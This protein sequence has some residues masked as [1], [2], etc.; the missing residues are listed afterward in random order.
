VRASGSSTE[1]G[2]EGGRDGGAVKAGE[3]VFPVRRVDGVSRGELEG[4]GGAGGGMAGQKEDGG[5]QA[6]QPLQFQP[7]QR[8]PT[9]ERNRSQAVPADGQE[10]LSAWLGEQRG[11]FEG[12][13]VATPTPRPRPRPAT[14]PFTEGSLLLGSLLGGATGKAQGAKVREV[15]GADALFEIATPQYTPSGE[16]VGRW[17]HGA[18]GGQ[19]VGD[20]APRWER[21]G[22]AVAGEWGVGG[23]GQDGWLPASYIDLFLEEY[24]GS[25]CVGAEK[26]RNREC[27]N[28]G[29]SF[30][31]LGLG[32][33]I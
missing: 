27:S 20:R 23:Q 25:R 21:M 12:P 29:F 30:R 9:L 6:L 3:V 18:G 26:K 5:A 24:D 14:N 13:S 7:P 19:V 33:R 10:S 15:F 1:A 32:F 8:L 28:Q 2:G 4:R 11:R 31:V 16:A 17:I 22:K